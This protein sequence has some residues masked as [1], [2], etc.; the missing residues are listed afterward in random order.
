MTLKA[1]NL[2]R[3]HALNWHLI[4]MFYTERPYLFLKPL[5]YSLIIFNGS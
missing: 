5:N 4:I 2:F 1:I 3:T